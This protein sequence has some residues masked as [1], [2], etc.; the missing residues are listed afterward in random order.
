MT[1]NGTDPMSAGGEPRAAPS[2][3]GEARADQSL[4]VQSFWWER[5][6]LAYVSGRL[7]LGGEDLDDLARRMGTPLFVYRAARARAN[8]LR[9]HS[10][11][12]HAGVDG[13]LYYAMKANRHPA[14]LAFLRTTGLCG[15]DVCSLGELRTAMEC[16]FPEHLISFTGTSLSPAE[17]EALAKHDG[18][19]V[20]LDSLHSLDAFGKVCPGRAVGIRI[21]PDI[22]VGYADND[23]LRYSGASATKFGIYADRF[24]EALSLARAHGLKVRRIHLHAGSGYLDNEL[25]Q[26][27]RVLE[28]TRPFVD[29]LANLEEINIGG[30]LGV[31]HVASDRPLDLGRWAGV[32]AETLGRLG[33]RILVEPGDYVIKDAG[34]L[35]CSVT[36]AERR[37]DVR[38]VGIDAGFN[39]AMEP[40]FYALPCEPVPCLRDT[41]ASWRPATLVGNIN[42]A[43]DVWARDRPM[44]DLNAGD[45]VALLNAGGYASAMASNHC[46]RGHFRELVLIE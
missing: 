7:H 10:A 34:A 19:A 12:A 23:M 33:L 31:P 41:S 4:S 39:L 13:A 36:Y 22:G 30:G 24:D 43:L 42:E 29:R 28:A 16:G 9:L 5:D 46:M 17:Y 35:I 40:V 6:D 3:A 1:G 37:K 44:P 26:F 38:F 8:L 20:N 27:R 45:R 32:I 14:L 21:N 2:A 15:I 18:V 25:M 11:L